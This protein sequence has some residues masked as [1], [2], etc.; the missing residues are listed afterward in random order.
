MKSSRTP[1]TPP[2]E[3]RAE[4]DDPQFP[5]ESDD[6]PQPEAEDGVSEDM[7]TLAIHPGLLNTPQDVH[8]PADRPLGAE[9]LTPE[10]A[11][12]R[13]E[14]IARG[15]FSQLSDAEVMLEL[16]SGNLAAFDIL[17]AKYRKPIIHFMF[18]MVHNQAV[19]EEL[20]QEV[21]LRIY[22]SRETYRAEA[23]FS[24]WLYRIATNLGVN[25]ARDTRHERSAST[26]YLD[27]TDAETG[28]TPD[29]AD[30]T[31]SAE[32]NMLRRERM[33]AIR[34]HVLALPERQQHAV[35]MHKY[36]GMDYKQIGEVLKLSESATKSLLFRAYQ[37]LREKLKDFV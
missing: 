25:H 15:D 27:E 6:L 5:A 8:L 22:R 20:A 7:G 30:S 3:P 35:L 13:A 24:T 34:Q 29:V 37:T 14:A 4:V 21:F 12:I 18:R 23:R 11:R 28:T 31:P 16:R 32:A 26:I 17:L 10:Q 33:N 1:V 36:E 9:A 19:A 2:S